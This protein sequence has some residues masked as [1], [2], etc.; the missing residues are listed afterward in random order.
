MG[1]Q[2]ALTVLVSLLM[3]V[4]LANVQRAVCNIL[5]RVNCNLQWTQRYEAPLRRRVPGRFVEKAGFPL[6]LPFLYFPS[7]ETIRGHMNQQVSQSASGHI[8][9]LSMEMNKVHFEV[10]AFEF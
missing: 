10:T 9:G 6:P 1:S 3:V 7:S 2:T 4:P 5:I 8:K